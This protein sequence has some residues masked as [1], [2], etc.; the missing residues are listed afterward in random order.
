GMPVQARQG[1]DT[2]SLKIGA[3]VHLGLTRIRPNAKPGIDH[4]CMATDA[5]NT[6]R[7][8]KI[9]AAHGVT[10]SDD[11]LPSGPMKT[12]VRMRGETPELYFGDPDGIVVQLQDRSYCGGLGVLG[13]V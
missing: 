6:D 13:N 4:F 7:I 12:W 5:F 2:I 8:L 1:T 11:E 9:L 10:K 3:G